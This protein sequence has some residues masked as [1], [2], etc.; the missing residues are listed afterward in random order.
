MAESKRLGVSIRLQGD[1]VA[2]ARTGRLTTTIETPQLPFS[3]AILKL[4]GGP[5]APVANPL[6]CGE[7]RTESLLLPYGEESGGVL[8][9]VP[10]APSSA[11]GV[12][13]CATP[14]PFTLSQ[15][16]RESTAQAGASPAFT[17]NL[18]RADAQQYL[19]ALSTTLPE[20]LVGSIASVP[21]LCDE[22]SAN[23]GACPAASQVGTADV[24]AGAGE[25]PY[26][27][28]GPVYLTGPYDGYPYGLSVAID[29][30]HVGPYDYGTIVTRAGIAIDP[31][32]ARVTTTASLPMIVGGAPVR[33]RALSI[34]LDRPGF[35]VNPTSCGELRTE[36]TLTGTDTLP[37]TPTAT[38]ALSTPFMTSGCGA[39]GFD[40]SFSASTSAKTSRVDGASLGVSLTPVLRQANV[41]EVKVTLPARLVSRLETLQKACTEKQASANIGACPAASKV[42]TA[43]LTTPLLPAP[44]SGSGILVSHG[45]RAFPDLDFALEGD[46][47]KL[48][49]VS[50]TD[51]RH[52]V[53]SST[54][55]ALPDAPFAT[56][57]ATF[58]A[59]RGGLLA[60][61][62]SLCSK[63]VT[64]HK[65]V[66]VRRDGH[67]LREHGH[68]VYELKK[69]KRRAA[70]KL[71]MPTVLVGQNGARLTRDTHI[72]V[73]GCA[74]SADSAPKIVSHRLKGNALILTLKTRTKGVVSVHGR[75]LRPA[76]KRFA[77]GTHRIAVALTAAGVRAKR[78]HA[79]IKVRL[80]FTTGR[81][82]T[83]SASTVRL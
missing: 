43:K 41:R 79:T 22:T 27:L 15:A 76:H 18:A 19:M 45:N 57:E 40:P 52:G 64:G 26:P 82:V 62:G 33:L 28:S 2:N 16:T 34:T 36:T 53:T 5:T 46:G 14:L 51:I 48:L 35:M 66:I 54:F 70:V 31:E 29:A 44:L 72:V 32:T 3:K 68:L 21:A 17:L 9:P 61:N 49:L 80:T 78:D 13:G 55:P 25:D 75:G 37:A 47:I 11:F 69:V 42:A 65:R 12:A 8:L 67:P 24:S 38:Q 58:P 1:V 60:A 71:T 81:R 77:A 74:S 7:A 4:K 83:R 10:A 6:V 73:A 63:T 39:L 56:F 59:A 20:G 50:H 30:T 23:A